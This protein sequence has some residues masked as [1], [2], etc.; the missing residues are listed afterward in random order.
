MIRKL[1]LLVVL[2]IFYAN[3]FSQGIVS[4]SPT[5]GNAGETVSVTI[6][7]D[8]NITPPL[9]PA[10]IQP[11]DVAIGS[12]SATSFNRTDNTTVTASFDIPAGFIS[13]NYDV[14]VTFAAPVKED[15]VLTLSEGFE[16]FGEDV[17][18]FYVDGT[19]GN[20]SND[21][22]SWAN[23]KQSIQAAI[24]EADVLGAGQVWVKAGLYYPTETTDREQSIVVKENIELY[25]GFAG[26]ETEL[27]QRDI[28]TNLTL[29]SGDIGTEDDIS[30]NSYHVLVTERNCRIDGFGVAYGNANGDRLDRCGGGIYM[31]DDFATV[32]NC[33]FFENYAEE[34][35]AMYIVNINGATTQTTDLVTID[36]CTFED[37]SAN[38]GGALVLRVGASSNI[39]NSSF[40]NND[41]EWRGGAIFINYGAS[42]EAPITIDGCTFEGN[43]TNGNGGAIYSDDQASQH[44]GTYWFVNSC[45]FEYNT[46]TH[47]GGAI[48]NFNSA[49]YP[50]IDGCNFADNSAGSGGNAIAGNYG[51]S[52]T[53]NNN[54]LQSGQDIDQVD[55]TCEG[56]N[57]P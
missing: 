17:P 42:Q 21:G 56:N 19:G 34:G 24:D 40:L 5:S 1:S 49:N 33:S 11:E 41:A 35:G 39:T 38:Y 46:A 50:N 2:L 28:Y 6:I 37:N 16:I 30:D 4:I 26:T 15:L 51:V 10:E 14:T 44:A 12:I 45:N 43:S 9:P 53:V 18:V 52:L 54:N 7:L 57:C 32:E 48:A 3:S 47:R 36:Y 22:T 55:C 23:A 25:G 31:S 27:S 13:G 20:D 29:L 8:E